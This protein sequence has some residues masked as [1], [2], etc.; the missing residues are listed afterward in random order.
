MTKK[1]NDHLTKHQRHRLKDLE[2]YRKKKREWAK[3]EA[4]RKK[5]TEYMRIWREKNRERHNQLARESHSRNSSNP[6]NVL[7]RKNYHYKTKYGISYKEFEEMILKQDNKCFLCN[8]ILKKPHLDHSHE[9]KKVRKI[10]CVGCN[11]M[12]GRVEKIGTDKLKKYIS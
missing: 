1:I 11:T 2:E 5:R 10:L 6:E 4:Q 7:Y 12:L 3:T 8:E 9:T